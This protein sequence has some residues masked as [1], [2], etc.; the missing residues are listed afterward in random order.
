MIQGRCDQPHIAVAVRRTVPTV[1]VF[2]SGHN[3]LESEI[4]CQY[5]YDIIV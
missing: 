2:S 1:Y 5:D 4:A 3:L